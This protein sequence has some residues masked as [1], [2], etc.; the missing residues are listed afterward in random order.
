MPNPP[1]SEMYARILKDLPSD[2]PVFHWWDVDEGGF[3]IASVLVLEAHKAG[4][5]IKPWSMHPDKVIEEHRRPASANTV[6]KMVHFAEAAG[7]SA[8]GEAIEVAKFTVEQES[9][10]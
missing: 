6:N 7:W 4:H 2:V 3:R 10:A 9:L 1:W 8:L 5:T